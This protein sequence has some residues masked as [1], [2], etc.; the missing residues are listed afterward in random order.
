M[1]L[2]QIDASC[3]SNLKPNANVSIYYRGV[4]QQKLV[5]Q[6]HIFLIGAIAFLL[7]K[8]TLNKSIKEKSNY[9]LLA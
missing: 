6:L 3:H 9:K 8:F 1:H 5:L 2:E 7:L 4:F